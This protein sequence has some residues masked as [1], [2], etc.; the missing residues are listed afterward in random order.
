MPIIVPMPIV[1]TNISEEGNII[2]MQKVRYMLP[3][4]TTLPTPLLTVIFKEQCMIA[5]SYLFS[6]TP[7]KAESVIITNV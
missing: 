4:F 1:D 3:P 2:G 5:D 7:S 6:E